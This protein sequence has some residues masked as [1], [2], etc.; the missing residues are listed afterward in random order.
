MSEYIITVEGVSGKGAASNTTLMH[1]YY[2]VDAVVGLK[3]YTTF[4]LALAAIPGDLAGTG[5]HEVQAVT[6][7]YAAFSVNGNTNPSALDYIIIGA[8]SGHE[9]HGYYDTGV[10]IS[11]SVDFYTPYTRVRDIQVNG[12]FYRMFNGSGDCFFADRVILKGGQFSAIGS[13]G[14]NILTCCISWNSEYYSFFLSATTVAINCIAWN[15]TYNHFR[16]VTCYNCISGGTGDGYNQCSGDYNVNLGTNGFFY[17]TNA[18]LR[19]VDP[20]NGD[21]HVATNSIL[22]KSG[23]NQSSYLTKD[24]DGQDIVDWMIGVDWNAG[25][26]FTDTLI[27]IGPGKPWTTLRHGLNAVP[28]DLTG[29]GVREYVISEGTWSGTNNEYLYTTSGARTTT[30]TDYMLI[31]GAKNNSIFDSINATIILSGPSYQLPYNKI[32]N[33]QF[34]AFP[35]IQ[36]KPDQYFENCL[37]K[38]DASSFIYVD[39]TSIKFY[40]CVFWDYLGTSTVDC[41][42]NPGSGSLLEVI[43]CVI[44]GFGRGCNGG[45]GYN[46]VSAINTIVKDA[47]TAC[48]A[49]MHSSSDYN[50]S[51]DATAP[52]THSIKNKTLT[53]IKFKDS[54]NGDFHIQDGSCLMAVG[55][56]QS[57]LFTKDIDNELIGVWMMGVDYLYV[58][59]IKGLGKITSNINID[60]KVLGSLL[61]KGSIFST[62][63]IS[64]SILGSTV[65]KGLT[66]FNFG[67]NIVGDV[68]GK[69]LIESVLGYGILG[70]V[71]GKGKITSIISINFFARGGIGGSE[72]FDV[73]YIG[74]DAAVYRTINA[75]I[76]WD[77]MGIPVVGKNVTGVAGTGDISRVYAAVEDTVYS[78]TNFGKNWSVTG[79]PPIPGTNIKSIGGCG[80]INI[81]YAAIDESV[82]FSEDFGR[83]WV[84]HGIVVPGHQISG[85]GGCGKIDLVFASVGEDVYVSTDFGRIWTFLCTPI[86]GTALMGVSG[87][88]DCMENLYAMTYVGGITSVYRSMNRGTDWALVWASA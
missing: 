19:F 83:T 32:K 54:V 25:A 59:D 22:L 18:S 71:I 9:H 47:K 13:G 26:G 62:T 43:N 85:I 42:S 57:S 70:D 5:I 11:S 21:F 41:V 35:L 33:L 88:A 74:M 76:T 61:G 48:F 17:Q 34:N 44:I 8:Q 6:G 86:P 30:P 52:G 79:V 64:Y 28:R 87:S 16:N 49:Y 53:D 3:H 66:S 4:A 56:D 50:C 69:G 82:Y 45:A 77:F 75:G 15:C 67:Y 36:I 14:T 24:I 39:R 80:A 40:K 58:G 38:F 20:D 73:S 65:G 68:S 78:S 63:K 51:T 84:L 31:R 46:L 27:E 29:G 10:I 60:Y 7:T 81:I 55:S 1:R 12:H 37:F 72:S 2:Y 23:S